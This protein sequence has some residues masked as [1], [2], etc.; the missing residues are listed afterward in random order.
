MFNQT[1]RL[2][3]PQ[4]LLAGVLIIFVPNLLNGQTKESRP[5][6][7]QANQSVQ[8]RVIDLMGR[9]TLEEKVGQLS[10]LLG[11]E[12]YEKTADG[13]EASEA[14]KK[15]VQERN[16]GML[17]ATLR[18]DPWTQKTLETGLQPDLAAEAT[19][20]MQRYVMENTRLGIPMLLAEECPHGHMAIGTTVFPTSIGQASTWNPELIEEMA[21]VIALETR[22]QGG[23]I[24]YGP[25]L[26]L[27]RE[28][29][30]SRVEET[31]GEDPYL[32]GQMGIAMVKGFQGESI[33][34]GENVISTLKHFTAYGVP[35]GGH[36]G[37]SVSVGDR[38]LHQSYLP[39]FKD[40]V[41]AGALS[42]MTAYN[43]IDGI[44]CTSNGYLLN[45]VLRDDWGFNGFVVSDLGS[46]SGL[47]GSHHVAATLE[48]AA[49]LAIDAGVDSDLG[50]YGF[51]KNLYAAIQSG[52]VKMDV[53]DQ[54]VAKVLRLKFEMGLFENPYVNPELAAQKVR[55][56][57]H[58]DLA[59]RV[60]KESVVLLK[61]ENAT[62]PLNKK[63]NKI[64]VIGPNADNIYN[65]LGDYTAPQAN[66]NIVTVLEGIQAKVGKDVQVDYIKGC[67]IRDTTQSQI[68][69][70]A[71]LAAQADVAV[72]V[73]GGSSARDFDTEYEETAAA[74][75]SGAKEGEIISDMESGEGFDRMTLELLGDQ[76]KLLKAIEKTGTPVVLVMIKGR[77]LNLNWAD[78]HI[79]AIVDAW[80][81]GQEGGNAI[82]DVLFGDYNPAGRLSISVPR[83]VGQL[84]VYYNYK[85]PKRH[86]YVEGSAE[87]LYA[88]GHGLSYSEFE[89]TDLNVESEGSAQ[90]AKVK[91]SFRVSNTSEVDGEEV[92]QLYVKDLVSS[93]VRPLMELKRFDKVNVPAG[94]QE[95]IQF[96]L[97]SDDLQVLNANMNR[98]VEPGTFKILV[99]RS[100][101]DIR[102]EGSFEID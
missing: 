57:A 4:L 36:N 33:A 80:Y 17:W 67:A 16:I 59:R 12:M 100:S 50:G 84:P 49:Q 77:P 93:T 27:A 37:T 69:E 85:N 2:L 35:E 23:H 25:V 20:A 88:F 61:N 28:P 102:L 45:D 43:S 76:M 62:L 66:S 46:I 7:K 73:L 53:L 54:A 14:F 86:D 96:E 70:A 34:S 68:E 30:W 82:A 21:S 72:V 9:M 78:E 89:Y 79:P 71:A 10:T 74:K 24:G 90:D 95:T 29:R 41:Q 64:A 39:P 1:I 42:V 92:V 47:K 15:A 75:V 55:S 94:K 98:L 44:P 63:L 65:Q 97:T 81:P 58:I 51:D 6:Y 13:V 83:S 32:N 38:E 5:I 26:D 48:D 19:N 40:A 56:A 52:K 8:D 60:A 101:R 87:P 91:V 3:G 22:L 11:W 18:A 31:Y 99:G